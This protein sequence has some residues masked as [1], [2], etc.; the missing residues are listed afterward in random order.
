[1]S[2]VVVLMLAP[3]AFS[4]GAYV[5]AGLIEPMAADLGV[6]IPVAAQLQT[7]FAVACAL[8]GPALAVATGAVGRKRLLVGVLAMLAAL[9][10][11]SALAGGFAP[12]MAVRIAAGL[13]GSLTLPVA[14]TIAVAMA[15][16]ERRA[17]AL[18]VVLA[19]NSLAFLVGIPLGSVVGGWFGWPASFWLAGGL[20]AMAAALVALVVPATGPAPRPPPGAFRAVLRWPLTGLLGI[21][22]LAFAATFS[23]AGLVGPITTRLT[24]A[25]GAGVGAVQAMVGVGSV[26]GLALGA[27]LARGGGRPL[28]TL[29]AVTM[30][31]QLLYAAGM[32][33]GASGAAGAAVVGTATLMGAPALFATSPIVQT[34]LA[35]GAGPFATVAFALN[36]SMIFLGQGLGTALG[37]LVTAAAGLPWIGVAGAAVAALGVSLAARDLRPGPTAIRN[38]TEERAP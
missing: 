11:L 27:R 1:V 14:S 23:T 6:S 32:L 21:T 33:M 36:G 17:A 28:P 15:G 3:F 5:F 26:I 31:A 7:A 16:P 13:V 18:A 24:G 34:R 35:E 10:A 20:C 8:G 19:G 22:A 29:F 12:L 2:R 38:P 9:N 4:T 30:G 37:G 25:T